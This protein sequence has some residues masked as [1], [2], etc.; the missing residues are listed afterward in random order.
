M[1]IKNILMLGCL[2]LLLSGCAASRIALELEPRETQPLP[3]YKESVHVEELSALVRNATSSN[4]WVNYKNSAADYNVKF[5]TADA[6]CTNE[7]LKGFNALFTLLTLG[8]IPYHASCEA[9]ISLHIKNN[10]YGYEHTEPLGKLAISKWLG[11][12]AIFI[13]NKMETEDPEYFT[14]HIAYQLYNPES[15]LYQEKSAVNRILRQH[16]VEE[17]R[18]AELEALHDQGEAEPADQ[19]LE[20]LNANIANMLNDLK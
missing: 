14:Q 10:E 5:D 12:V 16:A 6:Q 4:A 8:I 2:P 11:W 1:T 7:T 20:E 17:R 15:S 19:Q 9:D 18:M 3:A 13:P